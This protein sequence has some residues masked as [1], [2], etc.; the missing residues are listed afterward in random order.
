[1]TKVFIS[2]SH[3]DRKFVSE[4]TKRLTADNIQVWTD[5]KDLAIGDNIAEK[6]NNA[7]SKT[8][9]FIVVLSKSSVN[10]NWVSFELSA[11]RI[12]E[13]SKN[14][15]IILPVLIEDCEIPAF[16]INRV[17]AD[18][19][20]SFDEG[21]NK[22]VKAL[23]TKSTGHLKEVNRITD[24]FQS[25]SYE[26]QIKRLKETFDGGDL[27]LFC[28]AGISYE[29]GIPTWNTLLKSLL[30]AVYSDNNH[31]I[32]DID[33]RLANL[34][35]KR[36]NVS[37]LILAQYL[38]TLLGK[39]FASTVRDTLYQDC[40]DR[41]KTIDAIAEL[42][43]QRRG[44]KALKAIIT[45]NFDDLIEERLKKQ[46]I[47]HKSIFT[48][49][50]R[51]K[52]IEIPIYHP[53]GFLPRKKTLTSKNDIVFSEDAYHTQFIDPFSWGNLVQLNHLNNSTALF[54]GISLTD[55]N[56]RR[57]LDVSIRKNGK[58]E[59]NHYIIKK[60]Y[61][62]EELYPENETS[63]IKDKKVIPV[64][65]SIEEQDANDLGFNVIWINSFKEIPEILLEI[66]K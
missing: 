38:K 30:K 52:E 7:I 15:N 16:L 26:F 17:Y 31:N 53:H 29:A 1:M 32:P 56:M 35:Q 58:G 44:K 25:D 6:I 64:L 55:P 27:T 47:E 37:P 59:K 10:S 43:R 18:F 8:D 20:Y 33:T 50:E 66:A 28:G 23:K 61:T 24:K 42:S 13:I 3:Q 45:F 9:Y 5:E 48:E 39:K 36:I 22:L 21:Y 19:R 51:N 62:I 63:R 57:L 12:N 34:F 14:K 11:T 60:R 65:E 46:K 40:T 2:H 54:I 41:S 49:G 4:L